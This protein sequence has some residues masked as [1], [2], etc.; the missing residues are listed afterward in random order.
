[1]ICATDDTTDIGSIASENG[2][3]LKCNSNDVDSFVNCVESMLN[4]GIRSKMGE[5]SRQILEK[6]FSAEKTYQLIFE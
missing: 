2:F 5:K 4:E 1:M 3:G 6:E